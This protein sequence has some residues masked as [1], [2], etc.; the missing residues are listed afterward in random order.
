M[1]NNIMN[2]N[3]S[4]ISS[5]EPSL[6]AQCYAFIGSESRNWMGDLDSKLLVITRL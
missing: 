6:K 3:L 4:F 1:K 5:L 2:G